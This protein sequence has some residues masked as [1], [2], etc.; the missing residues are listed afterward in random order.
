MSVQFRSPFGAP[1]YSSGVAV[2]ASVATMAALRALSDPGDLVHGNECRVDADG[3]EWVFHSTST[4]TGDNL[5]VATPDAAAYASAGRWLRKT[6]YVDLAMA[7]AHGTAD[8]AVL[9]TLPAGARLVV[10]GGYWEVMRTAR[11]PEVS[12][13]TH[14]GSQWYGAG[15]KSGP[16]I[17][18]VRVTVLVTVLVTVRGGGA[19]HG[20]GVPGPYPS[21]TCRRGSAVPGP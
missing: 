20:S 10:Q 16:A 17:S 12:P 8:A 14:I 6:G 18:S 11:T 1:K 2:A 4:L 15:K 13:S 21:G 7:I 3:S 5:F 19:R 9:A